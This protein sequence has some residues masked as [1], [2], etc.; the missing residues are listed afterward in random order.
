[1]ARNRPLDKF[2]IQREFA[3]RYF[4]HREEAVRF[5]FSSIMPDAWLWRDGSCWLHLENWPAKGD[6]VQSEVDCETDW[7]EQ[8]TQL[9]EQL[10]QRFPRTP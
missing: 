8:A 7:I 2:I 5:E 3:P 4:S 9:R 6:L 10:E 1:M